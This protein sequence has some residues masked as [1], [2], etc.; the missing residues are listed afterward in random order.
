M[1][2]R[3]LHGAPRESQDGAAA[4]KNQVTGSWKLIPVYQLPGKRG[5]LMI[6]FYKDSF[7]FPS[8]VFLLLFCLIF[9]LLPHSLLWRCWCSYSG[10]STHSASELCLKPQCSIKNLGSDLMI[11]QVTEHVS[12]GSCSDLPDTSALCIP[13]WAPPVA[14]YGTTAI[15]SSR[16]PCA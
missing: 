6:E 4:E 15:K 10:S 14:F 8:L 5:R 12:R 11:F 3:W 13:F 7:C 1:L 16:V 2:M 9:L